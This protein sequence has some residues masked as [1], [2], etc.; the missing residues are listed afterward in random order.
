MPATLRDGL[1]SPEGVEAQ[2]IASIWQQTDGN[3]G[4]ILWGKN[5]G[6]NTAFGWRPVELDLGLFNVLDY[7]A[8]GD[9]VTDDTDAIQAA[10][11]DAGDA[12]GT[13]YFPRGTYSFEGLVLTE[14]DNVAVVGAGRHATVLVMRDTV[15]TAILRFVR[16][17]GIEVRDLTCRGNGDA[18][19]DGPAG[20]AVYFD[21]TGA[22]TDIVGLTVRHCAF[23]DFKGAGWVRVQHPGDHQVRRVWISDNLF[24]GGDDRSPNEIGISAAQIALRVPNQLNPTPATG[25][26]TLTTTVEGATWIT[27]QFAGWTYKVTAGT[28]A[29][30]LATITGNTADTLTFAAPVAVAADVTTIFGITG[31]GR[32]TDVVIRDNICEA[33]AVKQ[34]IGLVC[35]SLIGGFERVTIT[36]NTVRRAGQDHAP[37]V[38]GAY[39]ITIYGGPYGGSATHCVIAGNVLESPYT[40]GIYLVAV[41]KA[42]I[43]GNVISGQGDPADATLPRGGIATNDCTGIAIT[44]NTATDCVQGIQVSNNTDFTSPPAVNITIA[45]N[46]VSGGDRG[47]IVR[48]SG[49]VPVSGYGVTGNLVVGQRLSG[50]TLRYTTTAGSASDLVCSGNVVTASATGA[51]GYTGIGHGVAQFGT[52]WMV[53]DNIVDCRGLPKS[54]CFSLGNSAVTGVVSGRCAGNV[55]LNAGNYG[56][57]LNRS[58]WDI[59]DNVA[60]NCGTAGNGATG[61]FR[62]TL[63]QGGFWGNRVV[64]PP[65]GTFMIESSGSE[66]LGRD[67]PTWDGA[68]GTLIQRPHAGKNQAYGWLCIGASTWVPIG[69]IE[70]V[71]ADRGDASATLT[72]GVDDQVQ[73]WDTELTAD[74]TVT[75]ATTN[76]VAG[77]RF[78]IVRHGLGAFA[79]NVGGLRTIP[80]STTGFVEVTFTGSAWIV[81]AAGDL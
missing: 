30:Q 2:P 28:G 79:L 73:R 51:S 11:N 24:L 75:L 77:S 3:H 48:F 34:G 8:I 32:I 60:E 1:G 18:S 70:T 66:D 72:V 22:V 5:G 52:K 15:E 25:G 64:N 67:A 43:S 19:E 20:S 74:R 42:T 63:C 10:A 13:L 80:A 78:R 50:I 71:G 38:Q 16:C 46:S 7:G 45:G 68:H 27:D 35:N 76:A 57:S 65:S 69:T 4:T 40:T 81:T 26:T 23:E 47:I 44:G 62:T 53:T 12:G 61:A 49:A 56:F 39:A 41:H 58:R 36:G 55:A 59:N 17:N 37:T 29:G 33:H 54:T 6:S 21:A 31:A 9:G 14:K